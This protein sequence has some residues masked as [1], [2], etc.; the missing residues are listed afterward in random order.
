MDG[1]ILEESRSRATA[2]KGTHFLKRAPNSKIEIKTSYIIL[3]KDSPDS[4]F[5]KFYYN[6]SFAR[7][8]NH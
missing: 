3:T 8:S 7:L 4:Q 6:G 2:N 1:R 5:V